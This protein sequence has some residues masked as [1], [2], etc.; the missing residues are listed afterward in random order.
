M[1]RGHKVDIQ[2]T[3]SLEARSRCAR[4]PIDISAPR[5]AVGDD[6]VL[7]VHATKRA[8]R[9]E[10]CAR[11]MRATDRRLLPEVQRGA[12]DAKASIGPA[13]TTSPPHCGQLRTREGKGRKKIYRFRFEALS[14]PTVSSRRDYLRAQT[15]LASL[16][17][18]ARRQFSTSRNYSLVPQV[19]PE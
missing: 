17:N 10:H 7:A 12:S 8:P 11:A 1:G 6:G 16:R 18:C 13:N 4:R 15:V 5:L 2:R 9:E 14:N 3:P 19:K